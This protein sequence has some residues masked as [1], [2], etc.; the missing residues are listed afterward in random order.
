MVDRD[1]L[2]FEIGF[3]ES[4]IA[5]YRELIARYEQNIEEVKVELCTINAD[6]KRPDDRERTDCATCKL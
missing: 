5:Y 3:Y 6:L 1:M 2:L 4:K